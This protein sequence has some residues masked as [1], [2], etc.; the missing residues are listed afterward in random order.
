M[1]TTTVRLNADDREI[2]DGLAPLFGG[3]SNAIRQALRS[4]A[5]DRKRHL[6]LESFLDAWNAEAGPVDEEA[7]AAMARR[8]GL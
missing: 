6:A 4:L 8:Y 3:R 2:L 5:A 1:S 7:V